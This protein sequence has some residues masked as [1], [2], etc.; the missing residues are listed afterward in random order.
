MNTTRAANFI[1]NSLP[2]GV[3]SNKIMTLGAIGDDETG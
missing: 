3:L 1:F 2:S